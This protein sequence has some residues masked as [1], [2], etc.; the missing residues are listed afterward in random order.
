M[1]DRNFNKELEESGVWQIAHAIGID[2]STLKVSNQDSLKNALSELKDLIHKRQHENTEEQNAAD[3]EKLR[4][5]PKLQEEYKEIKKEEEPAPSKEKEDLEKRPE[6]TKEHPKS[7]RDLLA[8]L[9]GRPR[10]TASKDHSN[11]IKE[12]PKPIKEVAKAVNNVA[13]QH[14]VNQARGQH[15]P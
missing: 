11:S 3:L 4:D 15:Q 7:M 13:L 5:K 10:P 14:M 1:T 12:M 2:V 8:D 9:S 6:E